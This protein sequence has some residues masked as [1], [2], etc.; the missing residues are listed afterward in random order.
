MR[1]LLSSQ[2]PPLC[3]LLLDRHRCRRRLR[4][5]QDSPLF[6]ARCRELEDNV[7]RLRERAQRLIKGSKKYKV[8]PDG[9]CM[10]GRPELHG[11]EACC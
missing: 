8:W 3:Y 5:A 11:D 4:T 9:A 1:Q 7:D 2:L 10:Q 6:R